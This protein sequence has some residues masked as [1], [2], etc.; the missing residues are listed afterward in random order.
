MKFQ[1]HLLEEQVAVVQ[2]ENL[3]LKLEVVV[4]NHQDLLLSV[5]A[6]VEQL[7]QIMELTILVAVEVLLAQELLVL[8]DQVE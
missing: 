7:V 6:L 8:V 5:L 2:Q 1:D 3:P 4:D